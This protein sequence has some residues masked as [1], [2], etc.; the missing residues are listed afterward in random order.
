MLCVQF[1]A[2]SL[3]SNAQLEICLGIMNPKTRCTSIV[4]AVPLLIGV[5]KKTWVI[6]RTSS[7]SRRS[8]H[9]ATIRWH[10]LMQAMTVFQRINDSCIMLGRDQRQDRCGS[11]GTYNV[12][13]SREWDG[14]SRLVG[15]SLHVFP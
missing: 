3:I 14:H 7:R 4:S 11:V 9:L 1:L 5:E 2:S 13:V 12:S 6:S 8:V 10:G 15:R